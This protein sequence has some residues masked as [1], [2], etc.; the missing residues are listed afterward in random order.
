MYIFDTDVVS[1]VLRPRPPAHL[2]R[3]LAVVPPDAQFTTA[4]TLGEV[5]FGA[6]RAGR[7]ELLVRARAV[8][9][10]ALTVLPFDAEAAVHYGELRA[11]LERDGTP[12]AEPD[13]R[14]AAI[15]LA[16]GFTVVTGNVRHFERVPGL[17]VENW[18]APP[19]A[20]EQASPIS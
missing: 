3:R 12:L 18:I 15:A 20:G 8:V 6:A 14:I 10:D 13:L 17:I 19:M 2:L 4:I 5:V 9:L 11:A 16:R 1:H 7:P